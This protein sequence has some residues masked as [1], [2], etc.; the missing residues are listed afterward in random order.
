MSF[1]EVE[2]YNHEHHFSIFI[3]ITA[4]GTRSAKENAEYFLEQMCKNP[5]QWVVNNI[6]EEQNF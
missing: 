2:L 4:Y 1:Y 5:S 6:I 3:T